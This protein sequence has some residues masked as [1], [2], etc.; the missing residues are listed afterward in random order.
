MNLQYEVLVVGGGVVGCAIARELSKFCVKTAILEKE[1]DVGMGASCRNSGVLHAGFKYAP[2]SL[3]A[4]VAVKGNAMMDDLCRDLKVKMKRIGKLTIA[5]DKEDEPTLHKMKEQGDANG[6]PGLEVIE[7]DRMQKIQSGVEGYKALYSP[8]SS[9]ISPYS[10]TIGLAEN[11]LANG[12]NFHLGQTVQS[13]SR[14]P[15]IGW[16]VRTKEGDTFTAKVLINASGLFSADICQMTGISE[17]TIYPCRGEYYVLDKRLNGTLTTLIYP[18]PKKNAPGWGTH[19][20]PTVDG[21]ILIGPT[22]QYLNDPE[23]FA[24]TLDILSKLRREGQRL[25]PAIQGSDYIRNFAGMRAKQTP[26]EIGGNKDFVIE[27]RKDVQG[28]I[29]LV[30]IESPGL[31]SS[32]A[33]AQMAVEMVGHH[34]PLVPNPAFNPIRPGSSD[35]FSEL[36][37]GERAAMIAEDPDYGE[38]ICR[39]EKITKKE[40]LD[41]IQNPLGARTL[42]SIKYRARVSM[43][44]CQGGFCIPRIFRLLRDEFG[45]KPEDFLKRGADSPLF[46]GNVQPN[47][48]GA[49]A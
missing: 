8:T 2:G 24:C 29:N 21:N 40:V 18:A 5:L 12:V 13:I 42:V 31:T 35:F 17:Y 37:S 22:A 25:L 33:I 44:R 19:L 20:T 23:D 34:L 48:G 9:I 28:F 14:N 47:K 15:K 41:A 39:C 49:A 38:I 46:I 43:G 27:D 4:K 10:L 1:S 7:R 45:W 6:V 30:G 32:P 3:R 26:P 11:A 16:E 36:Q